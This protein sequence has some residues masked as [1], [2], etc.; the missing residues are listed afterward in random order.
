[1]SSPSSSDSPPKTPNT[2][3][4]TDWANGPAADQPIGQD[5][6]SWHRTNG[7]GGARTPSPRR[8][9]LRERSRSP[10]RAGGARDDRGRFVTTAHQ[11]LV[12]L[13]SASVLQSHLTT[14]FHQHP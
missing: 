2:P 10:L 7:E 3:K 11:D 12:V 6:P 14:F 13:N 9:A 5:D 4:P 1:M 8:T